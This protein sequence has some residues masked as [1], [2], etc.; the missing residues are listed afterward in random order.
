MGQS[1]PPFCHTEQWYLQIISHFFY[2]LNAI[3]CLCSLTHAPI[4]WK[5]TQKIWL[6]VQAR[7]LC[8]KSWRDNSLWNTCKLLLRNSK[9]QEKLPLNYHY[10]GPS[11]ASMEKWT[12]KNMSEDQVAQESSTLIYGEGRKQ[13]RD[14][15]TCTG[16]QDQHFSHASGFL[17]L[18]VETS[19]TSVKINHEF[20]RIYNLET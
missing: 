6:A 17:N 7:C 15:S 3:G 4:S 16:W 5:C 9:G 18:S 8:L 14:A 1:C 19:C 13:Y 10:C 20:Q 2:P 12:E 11:W